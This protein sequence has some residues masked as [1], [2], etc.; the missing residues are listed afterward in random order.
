MSAR[1]TLGRLLLEDDG[2]SSDAIERELE[3]RR[4]ALGD[5]S[6]RGEDDPRVLLDFL[7]AMARHELR[8]APA[9]VPEERRAELAEG[10]A[11]RPREATDHAQLFIDL[12][13]TLRRAELVSRALE[14]GGACLA[15][16]DDDAL[17]LALL[18]MGRQDV[19]AVDIDARLLGYLEDEAR[20]MGRTL[21]TRVVDVHEDEPDEAL[22]DGFSV[23]VTDPPRSFDE[24]IAF[25]S[26]SAR[27]LAP[28]PES[29]LFYADHADWNAELADVLRALAGFGL[30]LVTRHVSASRYPLTPS[31]V[32]DLPARARALGV[33]EAWL[34][35]LVAA[36]PA[37]ADLFELRPKPA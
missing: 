25:L 2:A 17:S 16:G 21:R 34:R 14:G 22:L 4:G 26:Y 3:A 35:E 19:T 30:E 28:R 29:R 12:D 10:L 6:A 1:E 33:S 36:V 18:A 15:V 5:V 31:W 9:P 13:S 8:F 7:L 32:P 24:A 11:R 37:H 27:C 23:V 20:A